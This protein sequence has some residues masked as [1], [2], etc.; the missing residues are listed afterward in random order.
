M[1][2]IQ[3]RRPKLIQPPR[4]TSST[5]T[6]GFQFSG[7]GVPADPYWIITTPDLKP[8]IAWSIVAAGVVPSN[9]L[10][11]FIDHSV[12]STPQ[13]FYRLAFPSLATMSP[14]IYQQPAP[15]TV[16]AGKN[17]TFTAAA[18][19]SEPF[20]CQWYFNTNTPLL[21]QTNVLLSLPDVGPGAAG[22]YSLVVTNAYG[23]VTSS[24]V[25]LTVLPPPRLRAAALANS[26]QLSCVAV[27]G[28]AYQLQMTASLRP[29]IDWIFVATNVAAA[30]GLVQFTDTNV[31]AQPARFYR[32]VSP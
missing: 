9:G 13:R 27:P 32:V 3:L 14:L 28:D 29:P 4:L 15:L 7:I 17:A 11:Q 1:A 20:A 5:T 23:S 10:V 22:S 19:G 12:A 31:T 24:V 26:L 6:N 2:M 18:T 25:Q 21:Y 8:P 16:L 30:S